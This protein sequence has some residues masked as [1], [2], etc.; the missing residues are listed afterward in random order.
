ME[1]QHRFEEVDTTHEII[2][3]TALYFALATIAIGGLVTMIVFTSKIEDGK[4]LG[5]FADYKTYLL[6]AEL[7]VF[8]TLATQWG[9]RWIRDLLT[10]HL[11]P[12]AVSTIRIIFNIVAYGVL[13]SA[14]ISIVTILIRHK[15][16]KV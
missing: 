5:S 3:H 12:Y 8:G 6:L 14:A 10:V 13:I 9:G 1:N 4:Y 15:K 16:P 7:L 11:M 2:L